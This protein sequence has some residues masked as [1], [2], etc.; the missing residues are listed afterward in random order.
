MVHIGTSGLRD[1]A[2][3]TTFPSVRDVHRAALAALPPAEWAG[4]LDAHSGLPGPRGNLE[5][6]DV[7]AQIAPAAALR[8]WAGDADEYRATVGAA[9]LGR[10]VAEG[11]LAD[12]ETLRSLA[13]D[14]RWRVREGVAMALQRLG[15]VDLA[16]MQG[17]TDDW[18][19]GPPLV[20]RA[21]IAGE[22][23]PRLL[24]AP[25]AAAHAVA[26]LDRVTRSLVAIADRR[27]GDVRVLRQALGYCWSVAVVADPAAGFPA[28]AAWASS[29]DTDVH[30]VLRTNVRK[31]RMARADAA[32]TARLAELLG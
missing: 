22:C 27:S 1:D 26:L 7:V 8:E 9:G 5:L 4:Y 30:W 2:R 14:A 12:L 32:E 23:E 18:S 6:L 16:R 31:A 24:R 17:V 21:A 13:E 10:L 28:L 3:V 20:Q 11:E 19:G 15:D 29:T 25:G